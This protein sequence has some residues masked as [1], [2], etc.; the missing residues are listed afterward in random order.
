MYQLAYAQLSVGA[1]LAAFS[2]LFI[3]FFVHFLIELARVL[4]WKKPTGNMLTLHGLG[5]LYSSQE[6]RAATVRTE[7]QLQTAPQTAIPTPSPTLS[8]IVSLARAYPARMP[9]AHPHFAYP[10]SSHFS[11][12]SSAF[13]FPLV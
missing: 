10:I 13:F 6:K 9:S 12:S 2:F 3:F 5:T 7:E 1:R 11:I 4:L 8:M